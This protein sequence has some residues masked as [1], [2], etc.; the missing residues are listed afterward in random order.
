MGLAA[1]AA[2]AAAA[3]YVTPCPALPCPACHERAAGQPP[4]AAAPSHAPSHARPLAPCAGPPPR[5]RRWTSCWAATSRRGGR[6]TSCARRCWRRR[7]GRTGSGR[8]A[9]CCTCASRATTRLCERAGGRVRVLG[10][11]AA[12][13]PG[14]APWLLLGSPGW[15]AGGPGWPAVGPG[16]PAV[17]PGAWRGL[18]FWVVAGE[19]TAPRACRGSRGGILLSRSRRSCSGPRSRAV[20]SDGDGTHSDGATRR[21]P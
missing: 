12:A 10:P 9:R 18:Q 19:T 14:P 21:H 16:W 6:C 4:H 20:P 7:A 5:S 11:P 17:G 8:S 13:G 2:A 15:P 1:A 3:V